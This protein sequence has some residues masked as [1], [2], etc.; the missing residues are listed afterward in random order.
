MTIVG[1]K[2]L[3]FISV[4]LQ[5]I[6]PVVVCLFTVSTHHNFGFVNPRSQE[7]ENITEK[8]PVYLKIIIKF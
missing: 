8:I 7:W 2:Y 3:T 5:F 4:S 1:V 6:E